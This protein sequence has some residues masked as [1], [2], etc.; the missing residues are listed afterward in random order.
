MGCGF[1][2]MYYDREQCDTP[3]GPNQC[4]K[5][6]NTLIFPDFDKVLRYVVGILHRIKVGSRA[7]FLYSETSLLQS[8]TTFHDKKR[9]SVTSHDWE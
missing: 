1:G 5:F 8:R 4:K 7:L 3:G 6:G 9:L 2:I